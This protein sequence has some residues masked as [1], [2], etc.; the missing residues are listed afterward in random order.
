MT[1]GVQNEFKVLHRGKI[2][3]SIHFRLY[4]FFQSSGVCDF[5][6]KAVVFLGRVNGE[7]YRPKIIS[8]L[9]CFNGF[10]SVNIK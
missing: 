3:Y 7:L 9:S 2:P 8:L 5:R 1:I 4:V 6:N 10:C